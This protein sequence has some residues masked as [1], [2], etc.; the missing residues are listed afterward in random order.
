MGNGQVNAGFRD[1]LELCGLLKINVN[2]LLSG[3]HID[4][5]SYNSKSEELILNL[6]TENE[7]YAKRL[8]RT[9]VY[10]VVIGIAASLIMTIAGVIIAV[11]NGE[12]D[13]LA[14]VLIV[15]GCLLVVAAALI[16]LGIEVKTGYY[17]CEECGHVYKPS[18]L[19]KTSFAM[20]I[21]TTRYMKCPK[22]GKKSWQK[23]V[24]TKEN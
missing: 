24:L 11:K 12:G 17:K 14:A 22:C 18:S 8:L 6:R 1:M 10:I 9:E 15:L 5:E 23:K 3:E 2:E 7:N 16:G 19:L 4:M 21:N 20:H 13:P